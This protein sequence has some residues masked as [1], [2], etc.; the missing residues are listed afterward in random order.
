MASNG[1]WLSTHSTD[2]EIGQNLP[3]I[4]ASLHY[5]TQTG[6]KGQTV[7][8]AGGAVN[9]IPFCSVNTTVNSSTAACRQT[10]R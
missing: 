7:R 1:V 2:E 9:G 8:E 6:D 4:V 5:T 3:S 10:R